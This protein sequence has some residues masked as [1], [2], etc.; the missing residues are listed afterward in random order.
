M[1]GKKLA[2]NVIWTG[3][4]TVGFHTY[5]RFIKDRNLGVVVFSSYHLKL[6]KLIKVILG[7]SPIVTGRIAKVIFEEF[8]VR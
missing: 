3:E 5:S 4:F 7:K 2:H 6:R 1:V 8:E